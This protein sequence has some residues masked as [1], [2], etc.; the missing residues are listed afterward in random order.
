VTHDQEEALS[1]SNR[2]VVINQGRVE[3][4]GTPAEI[5]DHPATLFVNRFV[6]TTNVLFGTAVQTSPEAI[7]VQIPQCGDIVLQRQMSFPAGASVVITARPE[8]LSISDKPSKGA[9]SGVVDAILPV[10]PTLVYEI[11]LQD[12]NRVKVNDSRRGDVQPYNRGQTVHISF[13]ADQ[14]QL[15]AGDESDQH[16]SARLA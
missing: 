7:R 1:I 13:P 4:V 11:Q 2:V 14:C 9:L 12:G 16:S 10:G 8:H 6:G 3:Q 15:F 5:Y